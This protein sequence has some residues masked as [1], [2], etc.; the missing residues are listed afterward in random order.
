MSAVDNPGQ[1]P[2]TERVTTGSDMAR[3][4]RSAAAAARRRRGS[5][6][7]GLTVIL[8]LGALAVYGR[9]HLAVE[10]EQAALTRGS[11]A[12]LRALGGEAAAWEE[13]EDAFGDAARASVWDPYGLFVLEVTQQLRRGQ[14]AFGDAHLQ[15]IIEAIGRLDLDGAA[16]GAAD[17]PDSTARV[18]ATRL[19]ADLR[20]Q[21]S[22][23]S[24]SRDP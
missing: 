12:L 2:Q 17:M 11:G 14:V 22:A 21:Q 4:R 15:P 10:R 6:A 24:P 13:A 23:P 3:G 16:A 19:T 1:A 18:W 8:V 20:A 5:R 9:C 7:L